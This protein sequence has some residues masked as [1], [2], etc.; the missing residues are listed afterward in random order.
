M[1]FPRALFAHDNRKPNAYNIGWKIAF[2]N[3]LDQNH[4]AGTECTL[5]VKS[6]L[7]AAPEIP[8]IEAIKARGQRNWKD[9]IKKPLEIALDE[10]ITVGYLSKWEYRDPNTGDTY[11]AETSKNM[12]WAQFS[13]L[14]VDWVMIDAPE[15]T[16]RREAK[17]E[18][19]RLA[20]IEAEKP[21][22]KKRGR[23]RKNRGAIEEQK[24]GD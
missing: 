2:H 7:E 4:A 9:K 21:I 22:K 14:V 1:Q 20:A 16:E 18:A 23:P 10:N 19:A 5:S 8:T 24:G 11:T 15:Q 13:R 3:G 6:L 12:T 17:A